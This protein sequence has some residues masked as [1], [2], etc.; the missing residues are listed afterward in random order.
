MFDPNDLL[1]FVKKIRN[2]S[3]LQNEAGVRTAINRSYFSSMLN[4]KSRLQDLGETLS[5]ND[6]IHQEVIE[7]VKAKNTG[8]ADKL[9]SLH[10]L[11]MQADFDLNFVADKGFIAISYGIADSFNGKVNVKI[12]N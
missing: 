8:M 2:K 7:K 4:A 3:E 10:E 5:E 9:N 11:R 6:D 1:E 12:R